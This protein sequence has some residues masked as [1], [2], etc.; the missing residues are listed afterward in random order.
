MKKC[1]VWVHAEYSQGD[2]RGGGVV[3]HGLVP[4]VSP[5]RARGIEVDSESEA[6]RIARAMYEHGKKLA[7]KK[8]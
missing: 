4:H 5:G 3:S 8:K 1:S 2:G 6:K 7:A